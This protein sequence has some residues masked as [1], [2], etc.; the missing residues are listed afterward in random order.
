MSNVAQQSDRSAGRHNARG[1]L[2]CTS[3]SRAVF[4]LLARSQYLLVQSESERVAFGLTRGFCSFHMWL[5]RQIGDPLSLS[6]AWAPVVDAWA[7]D[8]QRLVDGPTDQAIEHIAS[9]L[10]GSDSCS[11]CEAQRA[12]GIGELTRLVAWLDTPDGRSEFTRGEGLCLRH[13]VAALRVGPSPEVA[14]FLLG[15]HVRRLENVSE[16]LH[17]YA[18]KR[19]AT[20]RELINEHEQDAWQRALLLLAGARTVR[21]VM[22]E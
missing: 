6:K 19:D 11:V 20:R 5:L 22:P 3:Q 18:A 12:T 8:L 7:D 10:R 16:D 21:D 1:C 17:N 4:D 15:D 14:H 2:V 9:A 13:L